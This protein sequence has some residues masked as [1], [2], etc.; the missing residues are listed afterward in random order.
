MKILKVTMPSLIHKGGKGYLYLCDLCCAFYKRFQN[1][2]K[3]E[4]TL[5]NSRIKKCD[6]TLCKA[7]ADLLF[8]AQRI[9]QVKEERKLI[10]LGK[11]SLLKK[12]KKKNAMHV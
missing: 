11:A 10:A 6:G 3:T 9:I 2:S 12:N 8:A 1:S 7:G 5:A 4:E